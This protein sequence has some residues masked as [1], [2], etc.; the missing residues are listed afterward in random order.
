M[1]RKE[2]LQIGSRV[3][4]S[5]VHERLVNPEPLPRGDCAVSSLADPQTLD[6]KFRK[7]NCPKESR[8]PF[9]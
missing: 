5:R 7:R 4:R 9:S 2:E 3:L 8:H 1:Q 6:I